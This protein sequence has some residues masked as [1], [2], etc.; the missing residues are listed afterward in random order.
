M[1]RFGPPHIYL[2]NDLLVFLLKILAR[3]FNSPSVLLIS[4]LLDEPEL[5]LL[6]FER[7]IFP[8]LKTTN[9]ILFIGRFNP[10]LMLG[11]Y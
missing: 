3:L 7:P 8:P 2:I 1:G 11:R 4:F 6:P 10:F 9:H 5:R